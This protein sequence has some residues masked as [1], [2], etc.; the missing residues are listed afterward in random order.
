MM[1][2][3]TSLQAILILIVHTNFHLL[4]MVS[5]TVP[6]NI[7]G[8]LATMAWFIPS[9]D[10]A[11]IVCYLVRL[12]TQCQASLEYLLI[13]LTYQPSENQPKAEGSL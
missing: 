11:S 7:A 8:F 9:E 6:F 1:K 2:S 4:S 13:T 12:H 5:K 10:I 3:I